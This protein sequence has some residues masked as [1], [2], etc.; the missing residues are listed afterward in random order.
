M[1]LPRSFDTRRSRLLKATGFTLAELLLVVALLGVVATAGV[2]SYVNS[3]RQSHN[4]KRQ[5]DIQVLRN[6]LEL[7]RADN[8]VYPTSDGD[9]QTS[10]KSFLAPTYLKT[11]GFPID[12][13]ASRG[14]MYHYSG[15]GSTY[16]LCAYLERGPGTSGLP[17]CSIVLN[18]NP[19]PTQ[20]CNYG[21]TQP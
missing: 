5:T 18:C 12:P 17:N 6:A 15:T 7:Y 8:R 9:V 19:S 21:M 4:A 2:A 3:Q 1:M 20:N 11:G 10:L 16:D 13:Q 14:Y